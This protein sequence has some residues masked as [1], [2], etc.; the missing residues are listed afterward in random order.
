M[1]S[2]LLLS[3]S[4]K[5]VEGIRDLALEMA[6]GV[7]IIPVGGTNAGTLGSDFDRIFAAMEKAASQGEVVVIADL[8]SAKTTGEMAKEAL[9]DSLQKKVFL[10]DAAIVEGA[11]TAA[12][13]IAGGLNAEKVVAELADYILDK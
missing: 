3:H 5:V 8:G 12:V 10:C 11:V 2:L 4:P 9:E 1:V 6:A 13:A 7:N